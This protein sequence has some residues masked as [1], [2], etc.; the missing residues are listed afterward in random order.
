MPGSS[1]RSNVGS[2]PARRHGVEAR[3]LSCGPAHLS[4]FVRSGARF[5]VIAE[6]PLV[7]TNE[8]FV[9]ELPRAAFQLIATNGRIWNPISSCSCELEGGTGPGIARKYRARRAQRAH[10]DELLNDSCLLCG[11]AED[12]G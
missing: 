11:G 3:L 5:S 2:Q 12:C 1:C 4:T 7:F 8:A 9:V 10:A 6:R